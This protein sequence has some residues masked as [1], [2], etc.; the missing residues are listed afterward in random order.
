MLHAVSGE[1]RLPGGTAPV[2]IA[3]PTTGQGTAGKL[4]TQVGA[5]IHGTV[6]VGR[7]LTDPVVPKQDTSQ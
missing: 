5:E 4:K 3:S 2:A 7:D 1:V 6:W